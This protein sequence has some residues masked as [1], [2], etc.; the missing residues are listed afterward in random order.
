MGSMVYSL[1]WVNAGYI[2]IYIYIYIINRSIG[3]VLFGI[4][5]WGLYMLS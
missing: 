4:G 3:A 1:L 5:L 2:Y